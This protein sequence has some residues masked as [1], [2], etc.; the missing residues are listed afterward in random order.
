MKHAIAWVQAQQ[1]LTPDKPFFVYLSFGATHAPHH[2]PTDWS[3]KYKGAFDQGW[4]EVRKTTLANQKKLGV[5]PQDCQLTA[6]S[7]GIPAWTDLT[8]D[9]RKVAPTRLME[10]Y[11]GFAEHT[12][13]HAG[14]FL[15]ALEG[16]DVLDNTLVF[17]IAGDNG[18]S[19]EGRVTG[20]Y[21]EMLTINYV[22]D[23]VE[24]S[25]LTTMTSARSQPITTTRSVGPMP[26]TVPA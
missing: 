9:E 13:Y 15:D 8:D 22:K 14:L 4:D 6:R 1:T 25:W 24:T 16:M 21:N 3:D 26:W 19:A 17:Y 12:D 10:M 7:E 2:V 20:T 5:V 23:T 18:A 11:A